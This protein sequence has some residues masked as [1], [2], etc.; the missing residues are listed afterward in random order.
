MIFA[1]YDLVKILIVNIMSK[2][3]FCNILVGIFCKSSYFFRKIG[4]FDCG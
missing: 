4:W 2:G 1:E 3:V